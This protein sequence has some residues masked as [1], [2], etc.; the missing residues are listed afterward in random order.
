MLTC[1]NCGGNGYAVTAMACH[2]CTCDAG[3]REWEAEVERRRP[4]YPKGWDFGTFT[5]MEAQR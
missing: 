4:H 2:A 1:H 3:R 5:A